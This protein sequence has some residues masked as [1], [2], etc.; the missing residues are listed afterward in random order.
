MP[1]K[2]TRRAARKIDRWSVGGLAYFQRLL[3]DNAPRTPM[4][5]LL[6]FR[7]LE[8]DE[9]RVV[10][11]AVPARA[12]YN[13]IGVVHGGLAATLLD[14]ALGCAINTMAPPGKVFTTL[15]LKI[16]FTRPLTRDVGPVRCEARV[17][18]VGSRVATAEGRVVDRRGKLYAHGTTTCIVVAPQRKRQ[19]AARKRSLK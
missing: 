5:A 4:A 14:S 2:A 11:G 8:V 18:H 9:G 15:E 19:Q 13:G 17:I 6:N 12:H 1:R 10:F 3:A 16:N 7:L